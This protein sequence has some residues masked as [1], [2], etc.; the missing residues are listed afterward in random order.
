MIGS[1]VKE[2]RK[3][4]KLS[5]TELARRA[6]VSKSYLS[7]IERDVQKNP[8]LQFLSKIAVTLDTS[9][10]YLLGEDEVD[11]L[12]SEWTALLQRAIDEGLSKDDFRE[13]QQFIQFRNWQ[14]EK[15]ESRNTST[16]GGKL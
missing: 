11:E 2:L 3:K 5:I 14:N 1:R 12:D 10:E 8:S 6:G 13:F 15:E 9:I 7:Y 4:K 16:N